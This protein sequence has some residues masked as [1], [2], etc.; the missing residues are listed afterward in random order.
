M[1]IKVIKDDLLFVLSAQKQKYE[2]NSWS[3]DTHHTQNM[4][5]VS[6]L[7]IS[8][9][10]P[11][12]PQGTSHGNLQRIGLTV[13]TIGAQFSILMHQ[14]EHALAQSGVLV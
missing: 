7:R 3:C 6:Y 11:D 10:M 5:S 12:G 2:S 4:Q 9:L 8:G 14:L 13:P 1:L